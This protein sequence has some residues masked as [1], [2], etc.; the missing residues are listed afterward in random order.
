MVGTNLIVEP[1]TQKMTKYDVGLIWE[2]ADKCYIG[3]KHESTD[4]EI[5]SLGKFL[6]F[7]YHN[8]TAA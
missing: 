5:V 7:F 2:P 8:A 6:F 4:K 1:L 3:L